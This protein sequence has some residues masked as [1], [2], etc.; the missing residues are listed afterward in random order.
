MKKQILLYNIKDKKRALDIRRVLMPLKVP[1]KMISSKDFA[2]PIGYLAGQKKYQPSSQSPSDYQFDEEMMVMA[3]FTS[4][5][6]DQVIHGFHKKRITGIP[7]KAILTPHN[8]DWNSYQLYQNLK[9]EHKK[10]TQ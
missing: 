4:Y 8:Q 2:H 3:G 10:M 9:E 5:D 6:I 1:I 7:L